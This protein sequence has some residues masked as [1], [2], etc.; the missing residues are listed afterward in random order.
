MQNTHGAEKHTQTQSEAAHS[1]GGGGNKQHSVN[2]IGPTPNE[3]TGRNAVQRA[4]G[5]PGAQR[6]PTGAQM[7]YGGNYEGN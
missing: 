2:P 5:R 7:G 3:W 1:E 6:E 4:V